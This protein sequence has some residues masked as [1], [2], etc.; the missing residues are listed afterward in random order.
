MTEL[1]KELEDPRTELLTDSQIVAG[2]PISLSTIAR[3]RRLGAFPESV[4]IGRLRRTRRSDVLAYFTPK[5][6]RRAEG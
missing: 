2:W 1:V 6:A 5:P 4:R 3:Q